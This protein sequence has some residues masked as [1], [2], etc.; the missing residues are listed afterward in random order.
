MLCLRYRRCGFT[1]GGISR[2]SGGRGKA[3]KVKLYIAG[4]RRHGYGVWQWR[5]LDMNLGNSG[6]HGKTAIFTRSIL[7][8]QSLPFKAWHFFIFDTVK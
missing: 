5:K 6:L 2:C 4:E 7:H 8:R 3:P 1:V